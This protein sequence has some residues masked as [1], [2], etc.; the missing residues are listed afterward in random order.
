MRYACQQT[1]AMR[2][3]T[4]METFNDIPIILFRNAK[5]WEAWLA[6][7][8]DQQVGVWIKLAKKGSGATSVNYV[9]AVEGALCYG[10]IDGQVRSLDKQYYL[11]KFT[12]RRSRSAWS[13]TNIGKAERLIA[14]GRMQPSGLA[15][16]EA[17]KAD[18]RW[19]S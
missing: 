6:S 2:Y 4:G 15:A 18:G 16:I 7:H 19:H 10:W 8:A 17:A 5:A 9:E 11:Q 13:K 12:P 14:E 3:A 1:G